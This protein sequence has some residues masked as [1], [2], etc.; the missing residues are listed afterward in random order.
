MDKRNVAASDVLEGV[1]T[2]HKTDNI[3]FAELKSALH[4]RGFGLLMV[5]FI[6]P[7]AIPVPFVPGM[8]TLLVIP[9]W[10][11]STQMIFGKDSPWLP[12]WL[13]K[14][15]IK[16]KTL[17]MVVEKASPKL[18]KVERLLRPRLYFA[19]SPMGE[20]F[21]GIYAFMLCMCIALPFPF[22]NLVPAWGILIMALGLLSKDG[23]MIIIG[24]AIGAVGV[25]ITGSILLFGTKAALKLFPWLVHLG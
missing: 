20:K 2:N 23:V 11:F 3:T 6:L 19:S 8:T 17:A 15:S 24:M 12:K 14:K 1:V 9:V 18:R 22:T 13:E 21:I 5:I 25:V 10:I 16:R 4:E 7:L